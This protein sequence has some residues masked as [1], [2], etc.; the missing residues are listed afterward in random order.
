MTTGWRIV[1]VYDPTGEYTTEG[2]QWPANGSPG[3]WW[4]APSLD[5]EC[6]TK[7]AAAVYWPNNPLLPVSAAPEEILVEVEGREELF[8]PAYGQW[9][10][11]RQRILRW[12]PWTAVG[13]KLAAI[14]LARRGW[15]MTHTEQEQLAA[16]V[17]D[18]SEALW[19]LRSG[20]ELSQDV[21]R[22]LMSRLS[23]DD[24]A[25]LAATESLCEDHRDLLIY[26]IT[27]D[28]DARHVLAERAGSLTGYQARYL[29][30][31]L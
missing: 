21:Y 12:L 4:T 15:L 10:F 2:M 17:T 16:R 26:Q 6:D 13:E 7:Q 24:A 8:P 18:S 28:K 31:R 27:S 14:V 1:R 3:D 20:V 29:A 22:K 23:S 19:I 25:D 30:A 9:F 11:R 5:R